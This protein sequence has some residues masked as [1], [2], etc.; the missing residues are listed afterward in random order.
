VRPPLLK[1][2]SLQK[3]VL[4]QTRYEKEKERLAPLRR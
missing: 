2:P 1:P 4:A 3:A